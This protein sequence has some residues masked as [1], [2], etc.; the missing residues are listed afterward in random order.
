MQEMDLDRM[1]QADIKYKEKK[2][3]KLIGNLFKKKADPNPYTNPDCDKPN[4]RVISTMAAKKATGIPKI[5]GVL[6]WLK[7]IKNFRS[8]KNL[9]IKRMS[10]ANNSLSIHDL[11]IKKMGVEFILKVKCKEL[12]PNTWEDMVLIGGKKTQKLIDAFKQAGFCNDQGILTQQDEPIIKMSIV[13]KMSEGTDEKNIINYYGWPNDFI[14]KLIS[15]KLVKVLD[16]KAFNKLTSFMTKDF[17]NEMEHPQ[18]GIVLL[19]QPKYAVG[20]NISTSGS[21]TLN[22]MKV[23]PEF[24]TFLTN[25]NK[26]LED[27]EKYKD[28]LRTSNVELLI[29]E[30]FNMC[31][32]SVVKIKQ[33]DSGFQ[34]LLEV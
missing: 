29:L 13:A 1:K 33:T 6:H 10:M 25:C 14:N 17:Q 15:W 4:E 27:V 2:N 32:D 22:Q 26:K 28:Q 3:K 34:M 19:N 5:L 12:D 7:K 11:Q 18:P 23:H 8:G 16:G 21:Q 9:E 20:T 31:L 24:I 30:L